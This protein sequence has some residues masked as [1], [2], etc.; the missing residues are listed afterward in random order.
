MNRKITRLIL[1]IS[2]Y[3]LLGMLAGCAPNSSDLPES[4]QTQN[5]ASMVESGSWYSRVAWAHDGHP[6]ESSNFIIYSDAASQDSRQ[7]L[8]EVA[9]RMLAELVTEFGIEPESMFRYPAGR[10]K[11]DIYAYK[12]YYPQE[13]G[14]RAY[15][16]GL[17]SW[18]LDH[19]HRNTNL[20]L[21]S[22]VLKHELVHV[23][24]SLL[25]GRDTADMPAS[26]RVHAWFSE[27]LAEAVTGGTSG[28]AVRGR[29]RMVAL[30]AQYGQRNPVAYTTDGV[31][32]AARDSHPRIGF[33]YY[34]PMSQLAVEY[35]LDDHGFGKSLLDVR[36]IYLDMAQGSDFSTAFENHMGVSIL[37]YQNEFFDLMD[38]YL[39]EGSS[40]VFIRLMIAWAVLS[41]VSVILVAINLAR[42]TDKIMGMRW[43]WLLITALFGLIGLLC[44][45]VT[46]Q[47]QTAGESRWWQALVASLYSV[48]GKGV[49]VFMVLLGFQILASN[50]D[51]GPLILVVPFLVSWFAFQ[52]PLVSARAGVSYWTALRRSLVVELVSTVLVMG[53]MILVLTILPDQVWFFSTNPTS[54]LFWSLIS[55]S[56][57]AGVLIVYPLNAWMVHRASAQQGAIPA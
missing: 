18:S 55:L 53:G 37:E 52:A 23:V 43:A 17:V 30:I 14:M 3:L 42:N 31:I 5:Q 45:L 44:H 54:P 50:A 7:A 27:G 16:G 51:A 21:Y 40:I 20:S 11:I 6:Y 57:L 38:E 47:R 4:V 28:G 1:A 24:E 29:D 12:D 49:G 9:E 25:K 8:A 26:I 22:L 19:E 13:W 15:Y 34:Y 46:Y 48:T 36:D 56:A 35:L 32:V 2:V 33:E 39:V 10:D 41:A